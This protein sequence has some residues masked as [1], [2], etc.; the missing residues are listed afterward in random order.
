[1]DP[2]DETEESRY[3]VAYQA[4]WSGLT[5]EQRREYQDERE[6]ML[7]EALLDGQLDDQ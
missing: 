7:M 6:E 5:P 4:W 2:A 1:M 3:E